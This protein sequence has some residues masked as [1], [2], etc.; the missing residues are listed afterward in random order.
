[1][2]R[3]KI[4]LTENR[5]DVLNS[6]S[7]WSTQAI[8]NERSRIKNLARIALTELI[9]V[10]ESSEIENADIFEPDDVARLI[11][12]LMA[13]EGTAITPR[14]TY[15]GDADEYRDEYAYQLALWGRLDHTMRGYGETLHSTENPIESRFLDE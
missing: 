2:T 11:D 10:A 1:M 14:W 5:R 6:E 15:D 9:E 13:P 7:D 8:R 3:E 4:F 12:S